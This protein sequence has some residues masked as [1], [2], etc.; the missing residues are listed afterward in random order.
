MSET[1]TI[2]TDKV[3][4]LTYKVYNDKNQLVD[5]A[6]NDSPFQYLHGHGNIV[7]GLEHQLQGLKVGYKGTLSV[8]N[9]YGEVIPE[10]IQEVDR[11]L[12]TGLPEGVE[13]E[14]GLNF[15]A[16]T[17]NGDVPVRVTKIDGDKVVVDANLDLAGQTLTFEVEILGIRDATI[18]ELALGM[19]VSE[20]EGYDPKHA[21]QKM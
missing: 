17:Q 9:A 12:F 18:D 7:P 10:L 6:D 21:R 13:L 16:A 8:P 20:D 1:L 2:G 11:S 14:V 3:V 4:T 5:S 15:L 19:S